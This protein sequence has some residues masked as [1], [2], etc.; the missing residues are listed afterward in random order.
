[1]RERLNVVRCEHETWS[2]S[3][4]DFLW[5]RRGSGGINTPIWWSQQSSTGKEITLDL[6]QNRFWYITVSSLSFFPNI[7]E[8]HSECPPPPLHF[9]L[10]LSPLHHGRP[11]SANKQGPL[12]RWYWPHVA[13]ELRPSR[14]GTCLV[15]PTTHTPPQGV[16]KRILHC[17]PRGAVQQVLRPHHPSWLHTHIGGIYST[18]T[19]LYTLP[20]G[21]LHPPHRS[22]P[23]PP[24]P[25]HLLLPVAHHG[26]YTKLGIS[27]S[28][29]QP[30]PSSKPKNGMIG[31][32][33]HAQKGFAS[34]L[35]LRI[36]NRGALTLLSFSFLFIL[37]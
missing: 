11:R 24:H 17:P 31:Q 3:E 28:G 21:G 26:R 9:P 2:F 34:F 4:M 20:C 32:K 29:T 18:D 25:P 35:R 16:F 1:M 10:P 19:T 37:F 13:G 12:C 8:P 33:Y 5:V 30:A 23:P 27:P 36:V 22:P 15:L 6:K 7:F 14:G